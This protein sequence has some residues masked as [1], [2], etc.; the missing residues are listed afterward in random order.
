M[1]TDDIK[2]ALLRENPLFTN[3]GEAQLPF[4][5]SLNLK[6]LMTQSCP[7]CGHELAM[8]KGTVE[9]VNGFAYE[10]KDTY[11]KEKKT[12]EKREAFM[13][14]VQEEVEL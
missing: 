10:M 1:E 14:N 5:L 7:N 12:V 3:H 6:L 4:R 13:T 11:K 2:R 9:V 8:P